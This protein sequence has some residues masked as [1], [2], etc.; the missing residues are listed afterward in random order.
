MAS[1]CMFLDGVCLFGVYPS[2]LYLEF[3]VL[4]SVSATASIICFLQLESILRKLL[5]CFYL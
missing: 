3:I 1:F 5:L 4:Y 2:A